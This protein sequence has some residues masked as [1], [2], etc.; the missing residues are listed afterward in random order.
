MSHVTVRQ[1]M[2]HAAFP[3]YSMQKKQSFD[4]TAALSLLS[5]MSNHTDV[6]TQR[7]LGGITYLE[8]IHLAI[9]IFP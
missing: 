4:V 2:R 8:N 3:G 6:P 7:S 9:Y 5:T 1:W